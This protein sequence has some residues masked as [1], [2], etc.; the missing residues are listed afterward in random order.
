MIFFQDCASFSKNIFI[1]NY[2]YY[3]YTQYIFMYVC[4]LLLDTLYY[5]LLYYCIKR[6]NKMNYLRIQFFLLHNS[7]F[8]YTNVTNFLIR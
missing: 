2:I 8:F 3:L 7:N 5:Y 1:L 6:I 4:Y